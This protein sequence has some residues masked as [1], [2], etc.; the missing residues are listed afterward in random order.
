MIILAD[1]HEDVAGIVMII[2][3]EWNGPKFR[4]VIHS[5]MLI[6][7]TQSG[8]LHF[9]STTNRTTKCVSEKK[10]LLMSRRRL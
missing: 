8:G 2:E 5:I 4:Y 1:I 7:D 6:T 3:I 10:F 9:L